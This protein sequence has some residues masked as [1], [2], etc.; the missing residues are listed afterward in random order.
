MA[1]IYPIANES[2]FAINGYIATK[3]NDT[4]NDYIAHAEPDKV[5]VTN[6]TTMKK[7]NLKM[8]NVSFLCFLE[9]N[10]I[11][12]LAFSRGNTVTLINFLTRQVVNSYTTTSKV[13]YMARHRNDA[14]LVATREN[15]VVLE[16]DFSVRFTKNTID[17]NYSVYQE[18]KYIVFGEFLYAVY[19]LMSNNII[20]F[21]E[22]ILRS[23]GLPN[24]S[25]VY[26]FT[27]DI[28]LVTT[29]SVKEYNW[30]ENTWT[31]FNVGKNS[32]LY[33]VVAE[34]LK[35]YDFEN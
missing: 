14:L 33:T 4:K 26:P 23:H 7:Y 22:P 29:D 13:K 6:R 20:D 3:Y 10:G 31:D 30:R 28:I 35:I 5:V 9:V 24:L 1:K 17:N 32:N 34:V 19:D 16:T 21:N 15:Y 27:G 11:V 25:K 2:S 12:L 8:T 18:G